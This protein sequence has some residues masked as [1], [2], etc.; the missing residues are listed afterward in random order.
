MKCRALL[1]FVFAFLPFW[2]QRSTAQ[3][4]EPAYNTGQEANETADVVFARRFSDVVLLLGKQVPR[5]LGQRI[6][7]IRLMV[8]RLGRWHSVPFQIDEKGEDGKYLY[9]YGARND[10]DELDG[11]LDGQDEIVFMARDAASRVSPSEWPAGHAD[12]EE[13]EVTDPLNG[14]T[15][16]FYLFSFPKPPPLS[17]VDLIRYD[18]DYDRFY[19]RYYE[20]GYSRVPY[21]QK[22]V[23]EYYSVPEVSGGNG[24]NWFDSA[25]IWVRIKLFF[26][27]VKI[28]IHSSDFTSEVP[29]YIDG[30]IRVIVKKRT[31]I[32]IGMGLRTPNVDAD[33]VYYPYFFTSALVIALP[34]DPS[35]LTSS[36]CLSAGTDLDHNAMGMLFWNSENLEPVLVDGRMS[37][38]EKALDLGA[39]QWRVISG[40]QG[41]YLAKAVYAGN[42]KLSNIKIDEGQYIDDYTH[43]E[44]PENEPGIFGSYNW[45]WDITNGKRGK[46]V[47]WI[48]AHYGPPIEKPQDLADCLNVTD[49]PLRIRIGSVE[50]PNCLLIP[51]PGF[52]EE[53]LPEMYERGSETVE[54]GLPKPPTRGGKAAPHGKR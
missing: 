6:P 25:K 27:L 13:I 43:R 5:F 37:P 53:I 36:L 31:A 52:T 35:I 19:S 23:M 21:K 7:E 48:E 34:F 12:A 22:A 45:T 14:E 44:P 30:P 15:G 1:F 8:W 38:Q 32:K 46:Y 42:F 20:V 50:S 24:V 28:V 26:S 33:L 11:R 39:D 29:A 54:E 40:H 9:P 2:G 16:W 4:L 51:P 41:K 47:V 3:P 18:P 10:E 17:S 49:H